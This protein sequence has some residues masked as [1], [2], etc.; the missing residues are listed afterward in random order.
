VIEISP[1]ISIPDDEV[2][3]EFIRSSGPGGQNVNKVATA[4]RLRF[5]VLHSPSISAE[6]RIRLLASARARI[7]ERGVLQN[8]ARR[9]RTQERNRQDAI[10]RL[11]AL[12]RAAEIR[13]RVRRAT[14]PTAASRSRRLSEK[15]RRANVKRARR[16]DAGDLD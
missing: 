5:D 9:F 16:A 11:A 3:F 1:R 7:T 8:E 2:S 13:P 4:V 6:V 10:D 14:K 15:K 12:L